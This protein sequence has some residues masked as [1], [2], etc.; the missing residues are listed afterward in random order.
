[1]KMFDKVTIII[2]SEA[3]IRTTVIPQARDVELRVDRGEPALVKY[4]PEVFV[5][6]NLTLSLEVKP[7][8][9]PVTNVQY[10]EK[11]EDK[12]PLVFEENDLASDIYKCSACRTAMDIQQTK[13]HAWNV[14]H[15]VN[16]SIKNRV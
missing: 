9:H 4:M 15:T 8:R 11:V 2:E 16:Y 6:D 1:M 5:L 13:E 10:T 7:V 14:H 12:K 3:Q